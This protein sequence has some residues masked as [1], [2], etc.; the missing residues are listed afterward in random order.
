MDDTQLVACIGDEKWRLIERCDYTVYPTEYPPTHLIERL[1]YEL[2]V[3]VVEAQTGIVVDTYTL[4]GSLP[5]DCPPT[6]NS[7]DLR[8][9]SYFGSHVSL[10]Q[11]LNLLDGIVNP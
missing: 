7:S 8:F 3:T 10:N 1:R 4:L 5:D 6:V 2:E 9:Q 11:V